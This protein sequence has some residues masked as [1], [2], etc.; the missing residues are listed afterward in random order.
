MI[1]TAALA[2]DFRHAQFG[3][4]V[5]GQV[6]ELVRMPVLILGHGH[7]V[8]RTALVGPG[9]EV[10][11]VALPEVLRQRVG[12]GVEQAERSEE[13]RVGKECVSTCISRWSPFP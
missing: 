11:A 1:A 12:A 2:V 7:L 10:L 3:L 8:E 5:A 9:L 4:L 13:R 6:Q